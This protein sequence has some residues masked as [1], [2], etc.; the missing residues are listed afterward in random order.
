[1]KQ[2]DERIKYEEL[3]VPFDVA[4]RKGEAVWP[5]IVHIHDQTEIF[6]HVSGAQSFLI[7]G[8]LLYTSRCV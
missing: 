1:M 2:V 5:A 4:H 7:N 6:Y 3:L 8:C